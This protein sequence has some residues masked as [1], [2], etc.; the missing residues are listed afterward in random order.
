MNHVQLF[1]IFYEDTEKWEQPCHSVRM[2][3]GL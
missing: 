1:S 2:D 3:G